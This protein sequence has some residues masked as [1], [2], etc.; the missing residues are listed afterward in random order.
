M[1]HQNAASH[2][3]YR[4]EV[5]PIDEKFPLVRRACDGMGRTPPGFV[6]YGRFNGPDIV[7]VTFLPT[8]D[9]FVPL[10]GQPGPQ[11]ALSKGRAQ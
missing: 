4:S 7:D 5:G 9:N 11:T 1:G 2:E 3:F 8:Q 10:S 6:E